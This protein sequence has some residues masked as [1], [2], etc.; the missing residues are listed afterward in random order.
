MKSNRI[1]TLRNAYKASTCARNV[2][3]E[4]VLAMDW[5]EVFYEGS[6]QVFMFGSLT[7][8]VPQSDKFTARWKPTIETAEGAFVL[9]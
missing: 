4:T 6:R 2:F 7:V 8:S 5:E 1:E 9:A 3:L